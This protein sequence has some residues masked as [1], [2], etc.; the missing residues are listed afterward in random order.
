MLLPTF[1][2][3]FSLIQGAIVLFIAAMYSCDDIEHADSLLSAFGILVMT[4]AFMQIV[5]EIKIMTNWHA[6]VLIVNTLLLLSLIVFTWLCILIWPEYDDRL[7][8]G[9]KDCDGTFFS[10]TFIYTTVS[11]LQFVLLCLCYVCLEMMK[12]RRDNIHVLT[13]VEPNILL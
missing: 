3:I 8:D 12:T 9:G 4:S 13:D 7:W 1:I 2:A 10:F 11:A 5:C 6:F